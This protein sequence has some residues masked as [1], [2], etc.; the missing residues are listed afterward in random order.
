MVKWNLTMVTSL[1]S[2]VQ[3][4]EYFCK[5]TEKNM[6]NRNKDNEW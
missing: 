5:L 2:I 3:N 1:F 4:S 6:N